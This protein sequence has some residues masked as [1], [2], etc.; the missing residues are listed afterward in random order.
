MN[1]LEERITRITPITIII[2]IDA[3]KD[4]HWARITDYR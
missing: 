1:V 4:V 3:A 2:G